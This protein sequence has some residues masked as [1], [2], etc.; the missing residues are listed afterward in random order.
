MPRLLAL[1]AISVGFANDRNIGRRKR[2]TK[3]SWNS[4]RGLSGWEK[5][6]RRSSNSAAV[7]GKEELQELRERFIA[8]TAMGLCH[9]R[10]LASMVTFMR[11]AA[12]Q[13]ARLG[14]SERPIYR[15]NKGS[16]NHDNGRNSLRRIVAWRALE[17]LG[18]SR[19][20]D[21][22]HHPSGPVLLFYA[23][24]K[25]DEKACPKEWESLMVL[26]EVI[27]KIRPA[28]AG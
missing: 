4:T 15:L 1:I 3:R 8:L 27:G 20:V 2:F 24:R 13:D 14:C 5:S 19:S 26:T 11:L 7:A 12:L 25:K 28:S 10:E 16:H 23:E 21:I 18:Y 17:R 6:D 9:S 22:A